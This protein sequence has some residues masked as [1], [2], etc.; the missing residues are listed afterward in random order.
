MNGRHSNKIACRAWNISE[1][2]WASFQETLNDKNFTGYTPKNF[3]KFEIINN[4]NLV[5]TQFSGLFDKNGTQIYAGDIL[6]VKDGKDILRGRVTFE[7]PKFACYNYHDQESFEE[8]YLYGEDLLNFD[9][10]YIVIGN[11]YENKELLTKV[12]KGAL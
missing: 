5:W 9:G 7:A 2:R 3:C 10:Q 6:E 8:K 4:R 1:N 12:A 11:I